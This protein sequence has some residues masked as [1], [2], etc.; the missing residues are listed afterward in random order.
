MNAAVFATVALIYLRGAI[1]GHRIGAYT[2]RHD[3]RNRGDQA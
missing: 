2:T 3:A 1:A